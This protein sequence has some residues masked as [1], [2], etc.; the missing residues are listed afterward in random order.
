MNYTN[1]FVSVVVIVDAALLVV[2]VGSGLRVGV[3]VVARDRRCRATVQ[4]SGV[5]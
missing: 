4:L 2:A 5:L 1:K 3:A